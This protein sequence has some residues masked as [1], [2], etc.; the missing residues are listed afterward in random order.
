[1]A[2]RRSPSTVRSSLPSCLA[3]QNRPVRSLRQGRGVDTNL[4]GKEGARARH[5]QHKTNL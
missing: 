1:M 2:S 3:L 5:W 4:V